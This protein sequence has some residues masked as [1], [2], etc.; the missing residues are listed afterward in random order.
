[1]AVLAAITLAVA[2]SR[3]KHLEGL[4]LAKNITLQV[5]P[6]LLFAFIVAGMLQAL[7]PQELVAKWIGK[8]SGIRG[9]IV[10]SLAGAFL[11]G[12]P[13]TTL[14]IAA[15]FAKVGAS[16]PVLVAMITGWSLI[17]V[18]RLPMEMGIM[19]VKFT[20]IRLAATFVL[21]PAAGL[22]A[23]GLMKIFKIG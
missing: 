22:I 19:G 4:V 14:P 18:M 2:Y 7:I 3:G 20:L 6:L 10:G 12:G 9:I 8:E 16:I 1:M 17:A 23:Q 15:G 5:L 21:A 13:Y 11:P